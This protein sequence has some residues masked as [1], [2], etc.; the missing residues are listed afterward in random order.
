MHLMCKMSMIVLS[1]V[2]ALGV[3]SVSPDHALASDV[4]S[5]RTVGGN[6][7]DDERQFNPK[8]P[9]CGPWGGPW[10]VPAS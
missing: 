2:L 1:A 10:C 5:I 9:W 7:A 6:T 8:W 4:S 3:G